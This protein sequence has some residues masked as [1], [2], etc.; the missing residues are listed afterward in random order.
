MRMLSEDDLDLKELTRDELDAAWDLWFDLAQS[1]N[2]TDPPYTHG[3][4]VSAGSPTAGTQSVTPRLDRM[5]EA[6]QK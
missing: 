2:D 1:T 3:V 6:R 4:F 5:K